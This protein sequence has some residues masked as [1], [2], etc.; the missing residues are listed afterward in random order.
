MSEKEK[1]KGNMAQK[2]LIKD[3]RE[4]IMGGRGRR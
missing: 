3:G 1:V 4:V 2:Q